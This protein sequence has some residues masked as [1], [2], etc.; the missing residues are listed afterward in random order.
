MSALPPISERSAA[1]LDCVR[2]VSIRFTSDAV[3]R[4]AEGPP[5]AWQEIPRI[6][7][8]EKDF[9]LDED[10]ASW[11]ERFDVRNW[12]VLVA[13]ADAAPAGTAVIAFDSPGVQ[14]LEGRSDLAVL[15]DLRVAPDARGTGVGSALFAAAERWARVRGANELHVESQ[16]TNPRACRFYLAQGCTLVRAEPGAYDEYPDETKL[17]FGKPL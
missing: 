3:L 8:I 9:D 10:P 14:M 4:P 2:A 17:V 6:P 12:G 15:W 13:G 11:P 16:D 7:P 1:A 5:D